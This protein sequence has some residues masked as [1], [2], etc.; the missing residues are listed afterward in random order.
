MTLPPVSA[1][2]TLATTSWAHPSVS[3]LTSNPFRTA[4]SLCVTAIPP[5]RSVPARTRS[6]RLSSR[7]LRAMRH[8]RISASACPSSLP[9]KSRLRM[10]IVDTKILFTFFFPFHPLPISIKA[11]Q[12]HLCRSIQYSFFFSFITLTRH[13]VPRS[14]HRAKNPGH[15]RHPICPL[16][17]LICQQQWRPQ[18]T[19]PN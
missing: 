7:L 1:S 14:G 4:P 3:P 13:G 15:L 19:P 9:R 17:T 8:G 6:C 18:Y 11:E 2:V 10:L 5:S 12:C 16:Y